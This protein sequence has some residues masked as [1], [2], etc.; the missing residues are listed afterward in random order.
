MTGEFEA[1]RAEFRPLWRL[2]GA[3]RGTGDTKTPMLT[4]LLAYWFGGL[5]LGYF[6]CFE[7]GWGAVGL[8]VGL[9]AAVI[10]IGVVLLVA[11]YRKTRAM[12][13]SLVSG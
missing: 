1:F 5:P 8:R 11:W 6:L 10:L 9:C 7:V 4:H 2:A 12:S 13:D 3:L